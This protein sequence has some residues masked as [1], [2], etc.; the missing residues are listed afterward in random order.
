M[1]K[2]LIELTAVVTAV[3]IG[4]PVAL[5]ETPLLGG[6]GRE[7]LL[8]LGSLPITSV[9]LIEGHPATADKSTP[10]EDSEDWETIA[11]LNSS[12]DPQQLI[13]DL[14]AWI[15][16]NTTTLDADGPDV[17]VYVEGVQ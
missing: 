5:D 2:K 11:T 3:D 17:K 6:Q 15:R 7:G 14:P 12:S 10:A 4:A 16:W 13:N 1:P 9:I 8:R